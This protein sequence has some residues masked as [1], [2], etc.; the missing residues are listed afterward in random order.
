[1]NAIPGRCLLCG[2]PPPLVN[3]HLIPDFA[4]RRLKKDGTGFLRS[5][6]PNRR[7]QDGVKEPLLCE[8]CDGRRFSDAET[9]F[10][11]RIFHPFLDGQALQFDCS[12]ADR[13]FIASLV[14][15]AI[16][17]RLRDPAADDADYLPEDLAAMEDAAGR[18]RRYLL[19]EQRYPDELEQHVL[20]WGPD[21]HGQF[22]GLNAYLN[23]ANDLQI[24]GS[25]ERLYAYA[26]LGAIVI[27]SPLRMP[28]GLDE[29]WR[30]GTLLVPGG[31]IS[32]G[33]TI[34]DRVFG[35]ILATRAEAIYKS[36]D[37]MSERQCAKV[38]GTF[39]NVDWER[40]AESRHGQALI[41]D[42]LNREAIEADEKE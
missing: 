25:T 28:A 42:Y 4:I 14:W 38:R 29:E 39:R 36:R 9:S 15:R 37:S 16:V 41:R 7:V 24:V 5:Q 10:A 27:A 20:F 12:E 1:M 6:D 33:Q 31:R 11:S 35:G 21:G 34:N 17:S 3:G 40:L 30:G 8:D 23:M 18:L 26:I 19:G 22:L 32:A 2:G 13:Y